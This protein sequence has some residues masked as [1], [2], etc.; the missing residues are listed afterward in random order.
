MAD[1]LTKGRVRLGVA[2][3]YHSRELD[4]FR[5]PLAGPEDARELFEEQ[6][7]LLLAALREKSFSHHGRL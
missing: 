2:R 5:H 7:H 6:V 4:A 1:N 3:G